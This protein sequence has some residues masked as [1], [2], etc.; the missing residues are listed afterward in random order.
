MWIKR[1]EFDGF[2]ALPSEKIDFAKGKVDFFEEPTEQ[3][4]LLV[5][6]MVLVALFGADGETVEDSNDKLRISKFLRRGDLGSAYQIALDFQ[7]GNRELRLTRNLVD[8]SYTLIDPTN[9]AHVGAEFASDPKRIGAVLT[10]H[11]RSA[12]VDACL[13][14]QRQ[15]E[16]NGIISHP[17]TTLLNTITQSD[18]NTRK[19]AQAVHAIE[20]LLSHFPYRTINIKVEF[21]I[22]EL[23][24][25]KT[26][27]EAKLTDY[28]NRRAAILPMIA[29]LRELEPRVL[30]EEMRL[31]AEEY[32]FSCLRAAE[33]DGLCMHLRSLRGRLNN[34]RRELNRIGSLQTFTIESQRQIEELWTRRLTR[35][36]EY[37]ALVGQAGPQIQEYDQLERAVREKW[38]GLHEFTPEQAEALTQLATSFQTMQREID[39]FEF[40]LG[41]RQIYLSRQSN[42]DMQKF[43]KCRQTIQALE[44]HDAN[45]AKSYSA[46]LIGYRNQALDSER[47]MRRAQLLVNEIEEQRYKSNAGSL[48]KVFKQ[49]THRQKELQEAEVEIGL[50]QTKLDDLKAKIEVMESRLAQLAQKAGLSD[51]SVLVQHIQEYNVAPNKLKELDILKQMIDSRRTS[52]ERLR[53]DMEP[54][55]K[56]AGRDGSQINV[57]TV[58]ELAE[59]VMHCV[60]D[61]ESLQA[62]YENVRQSREQMQLLLAEARSIEEILAQ[63]FANARL[64]D[65]EDMELSYNE[66][67][68]KV[69]AYHHWRVLQEEV[70]RI[71]EQLGVKDGVEDISDRI[72]SLEEERRTLWQRVLFL[73]DNYPEIVDQMPITSEDYGSVVPSAAEDIQRLIQECDRLRSEVR[74]FYSHYESEYPSLIE[75]IEAI[76]TSLAQTKCSKLALELAKSKIDDLMND[77]LNG[78]PKELVQGLVGA[79]EPLPLIID[80][81]CLGQHDLEVTLALKFLVTVLSSVRQVILLSNSDKLNLHRLITAANLDQK[82]VHFS[83]RT[84]VLAEE[85]LT[86]LPTIQG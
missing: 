61:L 38:V 28:L 53:R 63:L 67:Y 45:D 32:F 7:Q 64:Q 20:E 48:L 50:Q 69:A 21:L 24:R 66:F 35:M 4:K 78:L 39:E 51:S 77:D 3:A 2:S 14:L 42:A 70:D 47:T 57:E 84:P 74:S 30:G 8:N 55:F 29:R 54:F 62:T 81:D 68:S 46:L 10:G 15:A 58:A 18:S 25:Q 11:N 6:A 12:F 65:P 23:V 40:Q 26:E 86:R 85:S 56:Q 79:G 60:N 34:K 76:E 72:A 41:Q 16:P 27:V 22:D 13:L 36:S 43:E 1:I 5:P 71:Y 31:R 37:D 19:E 80:L 44:P 73:V 33:I 52:I 9:K 59:N 83:A 75:R 49:N 82:L 17:L